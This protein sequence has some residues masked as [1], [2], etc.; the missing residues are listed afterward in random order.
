M[1]ALRY[2]LGYE[3]A[4]IADVLGVP[5]GTAR[6]RLHYGIRQLRAALEADAR[7]AIQQEKTA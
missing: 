4:D 5:V 1:V 2:Y 7:S 6:S 3:L